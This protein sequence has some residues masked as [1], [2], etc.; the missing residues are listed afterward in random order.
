MSPSPGAAW[1]G[2]LALAAGCD[3][4]LGLAPVTGDRDAGPAS[5]DAAP[6]DAAPQADLS[7]GFT[8]A[9]LRNEVTLTPLDG[10][11]LLAT[12][13]WLVPDAASSSGMRELPTF[14]EP[15]G[16]IGAT[17]P[18]GEARG[19]LRFQT[20]E[21]AIV[22]HDLAAPRR[23]VALARWGSPDAVPMGVAEVVTLKA[24]LPTALT[25]GQV[26]RYY[27]IGPYMS[28]T[29]LAADNEGEDPTFTNTFGGDSLVVVGNAPATRIQA[30]D[31]VI[32]TRTQNATADVNGTLLELAVAAPLEQGAEELRISVTP[33]AVMAPHTLTINDR[34]VV[35]GVARMNGF[36]TDRA[37]W[38]VVAA[39]LGAWSTQGVLLANGTAGGS[40]PNVSYGNPLPW[41]A[42]VVNH[43]YQTRSVDH[44]VLP[45]DN[46][47]ATGFLQVEDLS[48]DGLAIE[49]TRP[50]ALPTQI[51]LDGVALIDDGYQLQLG[52][53]AMAVPITVTYD[54]GACDYT[55]VT[56]TELTYDGRRTVR[57][58]RAYLRTDQLTGEA[59]PTSSFRLPREAL[60]QDAVYTLRAECVIGGLPGIADGDQVT[61]GLPSRTGYRDSAIFTVAFT[62]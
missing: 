58:G 11:A 54:A 45:G 49:I 52:P 19:I 16:R 12:T 9:R 40:P 23:E 34:S 2:L 4:L 55:G 30:S 5:A 25:A 27:V 48:V 14:V 31:Q 10:A 62:R 53:D 59:Q 3:R 44:D 13:R 18:P 60:R 47:L 24:A 15:G 50:Q 17:L 33:A 51:T 61:R 28:R 35:D 42:V 56:L 39:P 38:Q 57:W 8:E 20:A 6:A 1:L 43:Q 7:V 46:E 36:G 22:I 21:G 41:G 37:G 26:L 29:F 32:V